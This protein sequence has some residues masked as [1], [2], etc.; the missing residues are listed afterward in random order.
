VAIQSGEEPNQWQVGGKLKRIVEKAGF[1]INDA[2]TRM[3]YMDSRQDVTGLVVNSKANTRVE[4][5]R[6]SRAMVHRLLNTGGFQLKEYNLDE[7]GN[8]I[9]TEVDGTIEQLNGILSFIDS[10]NLINKRKK[11]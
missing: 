4:Y 5:R 7:S 1:K 3:Q 6:A 8:L 9:V 11:I 2:K 10:V